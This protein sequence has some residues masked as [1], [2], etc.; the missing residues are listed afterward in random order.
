MCLHISCG[1]PAL[2]VREILGRGAWHPL[3]N[4]NF[5][6]FCTQTA[7]SPRNLI[8]KQPFTDDVRP[9]L[10]KSIALIKLK[11]NDNK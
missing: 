5:P 2:Y 4:F 6:G 8:C 1:L 11:P 10:W 7:V 3:Y 9:V